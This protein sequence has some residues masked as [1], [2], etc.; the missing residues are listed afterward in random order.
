MTLQISMI[1]QITMTLQIIMILQITMPVARFGCF[2]AHY[3][4]FCV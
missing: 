1:L 4:Y 3:V 2:M